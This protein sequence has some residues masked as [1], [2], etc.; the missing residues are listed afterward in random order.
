[1]KCPLKLQNFTKEQ[2]NTL[3]C[4]FCHKDLCAIWIRHLD[5]KRKSLLFLEAGFFLS[6]QS[7][8]DVRMA[9][10]GL[11]GP[12]LEEV[13]EIARA[14]LV[15]FFVEFSRLGR[16]F[17]SRF[18]DGKRD[19]SSGIHGED[20]D[21]DRISF[22]QDIGHIFDVAVRDM[23]DMYQSLLVVRERYE[24]TERFDL[25]NLAFDNS[26]YF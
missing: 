11:L 16:R 14:L 23:G 8:V 1:M 12:F 22:V 13:F 7:S 24:S 10:V 4:Y 15:F 18:L 26:T 2:E 9:V 25:K 6:F 19:L 20:L 3:L 5:K 21:L 17:W